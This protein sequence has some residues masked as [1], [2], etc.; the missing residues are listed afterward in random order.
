MDNWYR[1]FIIFLFYF[2]FRVGVGVGDK[3]NRR[4]AEAEFEQQRLADV[5]EYEKAAELSM[6]IESLREDTTSAARRL[7]L[8]SY[9]SAFH[10]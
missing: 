1:C 4:L 8:V 7:R 3:R 5:E 6:E 10:V 2:C 9:S